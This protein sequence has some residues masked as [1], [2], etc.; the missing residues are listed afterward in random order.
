MKIR[1]AIVGSSWISEKFIDALSQ[2]PDTSVNAIYSRTQTR[3]DEFA[4]KYNIAYTFTDLE[5]MAKSDV[6][7]AVYIASPQAFHYSHA[8]VC[9]NNKKHV[10]CEKPFAATINQVDEMIECAKC[11]N[12][13]LMEAIKNLY[14]PNLK[15]IKE[16]LPKIGVVRTY[17]AQFC[18]PTSVYEQ[19]KKGIIPNM[20]KP[21]LANG[22]LVDIGVYCIAPMV[23]LFGEPT[24][25]YATGHILETGVDAEGTIT[26]KYK[27]LTAVIMHSKMT[28]SYTNSEIR[29]ENGTIS[30][31]KI[32]NLNQ[33]TLH[34]DG[35]LT[36]LGK[37][38]NPNDLYYETVD[39]VELIKSQDFTLRDNRL[40]ES[41]IV[42]KLMQEAREQIGV[43][44]KDID[45]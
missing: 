40:S 21:E 34:K 45:R 19:Y 7:D 33:I 27:N 35:E 11:N 6:F 14:V 10:L 4:K 18:R 23:R 3:A 25:L 2:I 8:L 44:Y 37:D 42:V 30:I 5:Q 9:M 39:F 13:I 1:F 31:N 28:V 16:T 15:I 24:S 17:Y 26:F 43:V 12:V 41:R 22:S 32:S 38:E 20:F 29:G 36:I